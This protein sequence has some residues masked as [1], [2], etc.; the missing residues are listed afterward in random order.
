M[1]TVSVKKSAAR[2]IIRCA[3]IIMIVIYSVQYTMTVGIWLLLRLLK[4]DVM[5]FAISLFEQRACSIYIK[6]TPLTYI[7]THTHSYIN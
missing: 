3:V 4:C 2:A 1:Y 6:K 7:H 5:L